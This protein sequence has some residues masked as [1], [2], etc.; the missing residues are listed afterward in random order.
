ME[1]PMADSNAFRAYLVGR[2]RA[3]ATIEKYLRDLRYFL[4][5]Q[6][7]R[8]LAGQILMEYKA[9]LSCDF[10][11]ASANSMIASLNCY[12]RF[13]GRVDLC[14]HPFRIQRRV[15]IPS[16]KELTLDEYRRLLSAAHA[17]GNRRLQLILQTICATGIRVSEL[18]FITLEA[19]ERG[20]AIVHCKGKSRPVFLIR[21]LCRLL[22]AYA[23]ECNIRTGP[24][25]LSRRG[26]P[27]NRVEIWRQMKGL[28]RQAG[29][30]PG[31]VF[32]HN[33]RHLFARAFYAMDK[34]IGKLADILGH[35]SIN[36][37][38]IYIA[39]TG[40]EHRRSMEA[41][42]LIGLNGKQKK[43]AGIPRRSYVT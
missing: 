13:L 2:D 15:Y 7:K 24:I 32:P 23:R 5:F 30:A 6:G 29:I 38:R 33:L 41:L 10:A 25:F 40:A 19:L 20:E 1:N 16:D 8:P 26:R 31:K 28:C 11:P 27:I 43:I 12:L 17:Q 39:S 42:G 14:L 4:H 18:Q 22:A 21:D 37:T 36:T 9:H 35:A 34:D 3:A